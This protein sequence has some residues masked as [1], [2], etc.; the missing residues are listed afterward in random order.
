LVLAGACLSATACI[1]SNVV[2]AKDRDVT[3]TPEK[4]L[5]WRPA[6][7]ADV[8]GFYASTKIEGA[9]AG[10]LLRAYYYFDTTGSYSGA[11]LVI[12]EEGPRFLVIADDGHWSLDEGHL[13]LG[14]GSG[15]LQAAVAPEHLRLVSPE[16]AI[17]FRKLPL[18]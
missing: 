10:A 17:T 7:S 2:A 1:P 8:A 15:E 11:A 12:G 3:L 16:S 14:D 13:D 18:E 4:A 6:R 5:A 9:S